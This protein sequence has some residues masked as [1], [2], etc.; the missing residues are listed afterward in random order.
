[1][2]Q[3]LCRCGAHTRIIDAIQ[4]AAGNEMKTSRAREALVPDAMERQPQ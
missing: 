3:N 1:M 4:A 2:E